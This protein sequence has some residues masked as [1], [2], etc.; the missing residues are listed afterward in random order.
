MYEMAASPISFFGLAFKSGFSTCLHI[1]DSLLPCTCTRWWESICVQTLSRWKNQELLHKRGSTL[2]LMVS[3]ME[4][5]FFSSDV[6]QKNM[7][8]QF[9][10]FQAAVPHS[11]FTENRVQD[12]NDSAAPA[13]HILYQYSLLSLLCHTHISFILYPLSSFCCP[14]H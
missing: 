12:L 11:S 6:A 2:H 1:K 5:R 8:G 10:L 4:Q 14:S 7:L 3:S 9:L 13:H